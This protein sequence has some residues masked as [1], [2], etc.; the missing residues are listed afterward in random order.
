MLK[1]KRLETLG[2]RRQTTKSLKKRSC[3]FVI[4]VEFQGILFQIAISG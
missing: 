3:I 1:R 4:A 2:L